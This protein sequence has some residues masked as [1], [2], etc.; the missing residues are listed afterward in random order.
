MVD[1]LIF[2]FTT[3]TIAIRTGFETSSTTLSFCLYELAKNL[4]IQRRVHDEIDRVLHAFDEKITYESISEMKYLE[5]CI[6][7]ELFE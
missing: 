4:E 6:E 2:Y 7:G 1:L 3:I 5:N